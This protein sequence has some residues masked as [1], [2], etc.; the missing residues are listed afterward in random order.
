MRIKLIEAKTPEGQ[1]VYINPLHVRL[2]QG[3]GRSQ[4]TVVYGDYK[5]SCVVVDESVD[6]IAEET[7]K[8]LS[9][10]LALI[11]SKSGGTVKPKGIMP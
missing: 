7:G 9:E 4:S 6:I 10:A 5:T 11:A 1:Y 8:S 3:D 2:I